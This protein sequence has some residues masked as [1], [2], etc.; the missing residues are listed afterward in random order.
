MRVL[1]LSALLIGLCSCGSPPQESLGHVGSTV[2]NP[3]WGAKGTTVG[4]GALTLLISS[5][6]RAAPWRFL[7]EGARL[8]SGAKIKAGDLLQVTCPE[9][10]HFLSAWSLSSE[11]V[12]Q[13]SLS[14]KSQAAQI[15]SF[16][17]KGELGFLIIF[18]QRPL[19]RL[20]LRPHKKELGWPL[21]L[22]IQGDQLHWGLVQEVP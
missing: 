20:P 14:E 6:P 1:S 11:G 8:R 22:E 7:R 12:E 13:I 9:D 16:T 2:G 3:G 21:V 18:S 10:A 17:L 15:E 5:L 4:N 19:K